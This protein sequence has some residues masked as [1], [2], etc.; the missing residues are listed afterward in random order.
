MIDVAK[1]TALML[2]QLSPRERV[3][4][5]HEVLDDCILATPTGPERNAMTSANIA[6]MGVL[7]R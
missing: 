7:P 1:K 5:L 6:L 4:F 2:R 3:E